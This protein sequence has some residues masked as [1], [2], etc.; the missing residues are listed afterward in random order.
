MSQVTNMTNRKPS[1]VLFADIVGYT[2]MMAKDESTALKCLE[3]FQA[4]LEEHVPSFNGVINNFYGDG[5][6][7]TFQ[8]SQDAIACAQ[9]LQENFNQK[10]NL[11][12]RIGLDRGAVVFKDGNAFGDAVNLASRIE[13]ISLGGGVLFSK[14]V[15]EDLSGNTFPYQSIG[16]F[17]FKNIKEKQEVFGLNLEGFPL[18]ERNEILRNSKVIEKSKIAERW[19]SLALVGS[20]FAIAMLS[21]FIFKNSNQAKSSK[22]L[23]S[24]AVLP[25]K[26]LSDNQENQYFGDGMT[27]A[28]LD[29]L[30]RIKDLRITSRTTVDKYRATELSAPQIAKELNVNYV[31]EGTVQQYGD[32]MRII[33]QLIELPADKHIWSKQYDESLTPENI[34]NIQKEVSTSIAKELDVR[35]NPEILAH[36][37]KTPT[38]NLDAYEAYLKGKE[39]V[40][41]YHASQN[42]RHLDTAATYFQNSVQLDDQFA[43]GYLGLGNAY[44]LRNYDWNYFQRNFLD[45]ALLY[46]EKALAINPYLAEGY[47][48]RGSYYFEK[49][50]YA[51]SEQNYRRT[52][53]LSPNNPY[54]TTNLGLLV[55]YINGNYQEGA[56]LFK[57]ALEIEEADNL[58]EIHEKLG[59]LYLDIGAFKDSEFHFEKARTLQPR[60]GGLGWAYH[61]QGKTNEFHQFF[62][63][64]IDTFPDMTNSIPDIAIGHFYAGENEKA[65]EVWQPFIEDLDQKGNEHYLNRVR[66]RYGMTLW[67]LGKKEAA[68][69]QFD[70][71]TEFLKKSIYM[72]RTMGSGGAAKY[73]LAAMNACLGN[74]DEAYKWL[75][76][77]N[78]TGWRW[79]SIHFIKLDPLFDDLRKDKK[80]QNIYNN[81]LSGKEKIKNELD[82]LGLLSQMKG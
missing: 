19:K 47:Q 78:K 23:K 40:K 3:N 2:A 35:L 75:E 60:S 7:T 71:C 42:I 39:R 63:Q 68:K 53:E 46:V 14:S 64:Y 58:H 10:E 67:K 36:L 49:G 50:Q 26:N 1:T 41:L 21:L 6:L 24:V 80:F 59:M 12:V 55:Y 4:E 27:D 31:L 69:K 45:T 76:E 20:V 56:R 66:A 61:A 30:A 34:L 16:S 18:P 43:E 79:G 32:K 38:N 51:L 72:G 8:S 11:T 44:W 48:T 62:Q 28:I 52:L 5:C 33:A 77:F 73:D 65:M 54:T 74:K 37:E 15:K 82:D 29:N 13:A 22:V 57:K 81:A 9:Q 25:F 70:I 17:R